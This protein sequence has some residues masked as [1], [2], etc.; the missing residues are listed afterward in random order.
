MGLGLDHRTWAREGTRLGAGP[1][2]A[3]GD[4]LDQYPDMQIDRAALEIAGVEPDWITEEGGLRLRPDF[5]A[6]KGGMDGFY[7]ACLNKSA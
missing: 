2:R 7:I 1:D 5:W 4:A 3:S 6:D